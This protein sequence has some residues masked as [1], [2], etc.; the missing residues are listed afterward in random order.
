MARLVFNQG[1]LGQLKEAMTTLLDIYGE[2]LDHPFEHGTCFSHED[3][4]ERLQQID[5]KKWR[6]IRNMFLLDPYYGYTKGNFSEDEKISPAKLMLDLIN[7]MD[8]IKTDQVNKLEHY[9]AIM[10]KL[11]KEKTDTENTLAKTERQLREE[12]SYNTADRTE[13][14]TAQGS[15]TFLEG[16]LKEK[17]EKI[18]EL[19]REKNV[20]LWEREKER[21]FA[22]TEKKIKNLEN[23]IAEQKRSNE[24]MTRKL[25][26]IEE[27]N[28]VLRMKQDLSKG[29]LPPSTNKSSEELKRAIYLLEKDV[30]FLEQN[31]YEQQRTFATI[32]LGLKTDLLII[33]DNLTDPDTGQVIDK[34]FVRVCDI[35]GKVFNAMREGEILDAQKTLPPHYSYLPSDFKIK[36]IKRISRSK[37]KVPLHSNGNGSDAVLPPLRGDQ[38]DLSERITVRNEDLLGHNEIESDIVENPNLIDPISKQVNTTLC[39][40]HFPHMST[41]F[42]KDHWVRFKELDVDGN[43]CLDF[44]EVVKALTSMGMQF[45]AQQAEEA[46]READINKSRTLDFYEYLLTADKLFSKKGHSELFHTGPA[47]E[48]RKAIAKTCLTNAAEAVVAVVLVVAVVVVVVVI[49]IVLVVVVVLLLLTLLLLVKVEVAEAVIVVVVVLLVVVVVVVVV[50]G[51]VVVVVVVVVRVVVVVVVVV[52]VIVIVVVVAVVIVKVVFTQHC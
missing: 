30:I 38:P 43:E 35:T 32:L 3:V 1:N 17:N 52:V 10:A 39:M 40:K 44:G 20:Q 19:Q 37:V 13:I 47:K 34:D 2:M 16:V 46:M 6:P 4:M 41:E 27:T 18:A 31:L 33:S 5:Q 36:R 7:V 51:G 45:T 26:Q 49:V 11:T 22:E 9:Q 14:K 12:R 8:Q 23:E 50:A 42:V 48:N 24:I 28:K 29:T 15:I 21:L 25:L